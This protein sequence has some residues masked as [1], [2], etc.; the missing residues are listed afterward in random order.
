MTSPASTQEEEEE[1]T[2]SASTHSNYAP[3]EQEQ[4]LTGGRWYHR[5]HG[6]PMQKPPTGVGEKRAGLGSRLL[7]W[8]LVL[9]T[10]LFVFY[11]LYFTLSYLTPH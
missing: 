2:R 11:V 10:W 8:A 9:F 3:P 5:V 4:E 6:P 1:V 7:D